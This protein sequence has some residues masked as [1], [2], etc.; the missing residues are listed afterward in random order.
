MLIV[1]KLV[2]DLMHLWMFEYSFNQWFE[3]DFTKVINLFKFLQYQIA[4]F[5]CLIFALKQLCQIVEDELVS[6][7]PVGFESLKRMCLSEQFLTDDK[8]NL[9]NFHQ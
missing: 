2:V 6:L 3:T 7:L 4:L 8:V 9:T 1:N 5:L